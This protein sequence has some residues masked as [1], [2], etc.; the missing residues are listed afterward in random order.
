VQ[1]FLLLRHSLHTC[2]L[3]QNGTGSLSKPAAVNAYRFPGYVPLQSK[4]NRHSQYSTGDMNTLCAARVEARKN[5]ESNRNLR[6]G[7]EELEKS[8]VHAEEVGKFLRENVVQG[9]AAGADNY[10]MLQHVMSAH[11]ILHS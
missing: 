5:F 7:S 9:Q 10:S 6:V 3:A 2:N 8:L 11:V 1:N 4:R